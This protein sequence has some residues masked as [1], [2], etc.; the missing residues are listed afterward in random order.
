MRKLFRAIK[1]TL[2][3]SY[4]RGT[5]QYDVLC[6]LILLFVFALPAAWFDERGA[7][8]K[9]LAQT[10]PA[11]TRAEFFSIHDLGGVPNAPTLHE[12]LSAAVAARHGR[13]LKIAHFEVVSD[14]SGAAVSGYRVWI[15]APT[16]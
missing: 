13:P 16:R 8:Q 7:A 4:D 5:W 2:L 11:A 10:L 9:S 15:E 12:L 3:W 6:V 1:A 14:A